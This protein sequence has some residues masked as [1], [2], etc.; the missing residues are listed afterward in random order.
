[1][2]AN[3]SGGVIPQTPIWR[4][5]TACS[6]SFRTVF[7]AYDVTTKACVKLITQINYDNSKDQE[8]VNDTTLTS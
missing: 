7:I 1:V 4:M 2:T 6:S 3:V 5:S 8:N